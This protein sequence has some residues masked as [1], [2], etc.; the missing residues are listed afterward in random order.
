MSDPSRS[1]RKSVE[2]RVLALALARISTICLRIQIS[3]PGL[4][5]THSITSATRRTDSWSNGESNPNIRWPLPATVCSRATIH[6]SAS[7]NDT[8]F[9]KSGKT[10]RQ[11][12]AAVFVMRKLLLTT[13]HAT[14]HALYPE[15]G[16]YC[17]C[18]N[19]K[20]SACCSKCSSCSYKV[21]FIDTCQGSK[22][23]EKC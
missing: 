14:C 21:G 1:R 23:S 11:L 2:E 13:S 16:C 17:E 12:V 7:T 19:G 3:K 22:H 4:M 6:S 15:V 10:G 8:P 5:P 9:R 20:R 18:N